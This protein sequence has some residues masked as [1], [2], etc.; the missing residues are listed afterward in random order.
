MVF[1]DIRAPKQ[2][3]P[4]DELGA[5]SD[6]QHASLEVKRQRVDSESEEESRK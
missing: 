1:F 5:E 6:G 2:E 4:V 3:C